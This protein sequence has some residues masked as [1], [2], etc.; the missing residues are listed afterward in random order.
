MAEYIRAPLSDIF[1]GDRLRTINP[2]KVEARAASMAEHGQITP[3]SIRRTPAKN[4]GATPF[5][6]IAGEYRLAAA[7]LLGWA[8]IDAVIVKA[9]STDAQMIE[10]AENLHRDELTVLEHSVFVMKYRELWEAKHGKIERGGDRR[11]KGQ[12]APLKLANGRVLSVQVQER[13][14]LGADA[15]KRAVRIGK[16]LHPT[17]RAA[18]LGTEA[19][20]DQ[21]KL[22]KLAKLPA[23]DQL[24]VAASLK[25][26]PD[27]QLALSWLK[28]EKPP[29]DAEAEL[30]KKLITAWDRANEETRHAFLIHAGV[31]QDTA[32]VDLM[33]SIKQ[34]AAAA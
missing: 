11:S 17:L 2:L 9:D 30:L 29:V 23:D 24:R 34:E 13:L 19:E 14:G 27:L 16:N 6:L 20:T 8:E 5:S 26:K 1:V 33:T 3:I 12:D 21:S 22:L 18:V 15:Y 7:T 28:P 25:E 4:K 10:I 31:E 32:L